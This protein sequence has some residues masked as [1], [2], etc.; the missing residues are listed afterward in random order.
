MGFTKLVI[1][2]IYNLPALK[3]FLSFVAA[4]VQFSAIYAYSCFLSLEVSL[5]W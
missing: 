2:F 4:L 5:R 1:E 3:Q